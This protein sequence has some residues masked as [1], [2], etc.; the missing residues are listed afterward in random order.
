MAL[1]SDDR[2]DLERAKLIESTATT[3]QVAVAVINP[4]GS[5]IG[6]SG[7]TSSADDADFAAGSTSGTPAMG[8]YEST[9]TTVTD[10]DLGV[11]GITTNRELKVSVTSGSASGTEYTEGDVDTTFSGPL[12]LVEGPSNAATP[13]LVDANQHLQVDIAA[14]SAGIGGG[15]QYTEGDTD[16]TITGTALMF[17]GGSDTLVAAPGTAVNGLDVDVTRV[18]GTVTISDPN[19]IDSNNSTTSTLAGGATYTGT[20]RDVSEYASV[21]IQLDSS[22]NSATDGMTFQFSTDNTNWDDIYQFTYTASQGARRFQFPVTAQYFRVVYT[23]GATPQTHFRVQTILH[24]KT[25]LTS[26]HRVEDNVSP[27]R[28]ATLTKSV[29]A[30]QVNGTGDFTPIQANSAGVLKIGGS[31]DVDSSALPTGAS[32]LAE[33]QSQTSLLTTID[34]DTS[35]IAG[36][37]TSLDGKVLADTT[38]DLDSGAGTDTVKV[39]GIAVAAN[40]GHAVVTGDTTNGLDVDVTRVS[41]TVTVDN[42]G[43]TELAAAINSSQLDINIASDSVG[44]GGGTQ[45]TEDAAAAADPVGNAQILVRADSLGAVTSADGDN[46]AARGTNKGELY[47]KHADVI[48]VDATG[49]GDVPI[50]LGGEAVVLGAGTAVIGKARLVTATG[51]EVTEDTNDTVKVTI[52]A[53]DVG[54][55]GGTQY[56]EDTAH[57]TGD[58]GTMALAVRDDTTP[59]TLS[60][61]DGDY[62]PLHLDGNGNLWVSLGTKLDQANDAV[63]IYGSDDGGTTKRIIETDAGGAVAIQDGGNS[64]T[65]DG[66]V[67]ET[68]SASILADT[69]S[70]DTN[71]GTVAGAVAGSE[72]QVDVVASL[73]AGTNNIGDVDVLSLIPGTGSTNLGK[74]EDA[75]HASGHTGVM[76]LG[77]RN[78]SNATSFS[79]ANGDYT[80]LAVDANGNLQVDVL[81]AP[82]TTVT[83]TVT[84]NLS[85][86]DNAVLD[87]IELNQ[88]SQTAILTTIDTDTGNIAT[89]TSTIAGVVSGSE[90]QVDVVGSLPA[91]TN[92]IGKLS[93]NS[94]V[95]IGDVD[96]TSISAGSNLIG[97]VGIQGRTTGGLSTYYDSDLDE[98]AVSVKASAGTI[99]AIEAFNT[100]DAPLFLQLF[101]VASGS[102]TVGTTTPT[103]QW[104]IPGNANSDGAGFTFNV[105][106]GIAYGTAI[107]A[108]CTTDSE[109]SA[110]PGAGAC[111]VNIHYK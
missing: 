73:P 66:T 107:T 98:T 22:H 20:G 81:S 27:D 3:G 71:L 83:G 90:M 102:V 64:I 80:P 101:N 99:Y 87:Q 76:A 33:Q 56:A 72:M 100:T 30:A 93:A 82:T 74:A 18:S 11:V 109:G 89:N 48:S 28:S 62:E 84:A 6:G 111:I 52:T 36:D 14:D 53:D 15:I 5:N 35:T 54:I 17:E 29:L 44:I 46:V 94:G 45:Y 9:P 105:P 58:T 23:N 77:V 49:Q 88:D 61:A 55:G 70:M 16:T 68:N 32:T 39:Q 91:G 10:G 34:T 47:V 1:P 85:A 63:A 75:A 13:L 110:A 96:V 104:V 37:T 19:M 2:N 92:A 69:A 60:S 86:T 50:T 95:D 65:V 79:S 108:A 78:D 24:K 42:A 12:V 57:T 38:D 4:D 40:G 67:T 26:I 59:A 25:V 41:G 97:D 103:N 8:V 43:L 21:T 31:V 7:G 106:Q 51:D